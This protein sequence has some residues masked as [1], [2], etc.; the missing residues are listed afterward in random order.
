[1][2]VDYRKVSK[3]DAYPMPNV[4][5]ILDK[6][7]PA[8]FISTLDLAQGYWR[9]PMAADSQ[10]VTAFTT[11]YGLLEFTVMPFGLHNA[12]TTFQ[13][14]MNEVLSDC[15][16]FSKS[17]IDDVVVL[18]HYL[19]YVM[20]EG[21]IEPDP[22]KVE[23]VKQPVTNS[24]VRAFH[25][26]ASYYRK[27]VP[28]FATRAAPLTELLKKRQH[29]EIVWTEKCGKAFRDLKSA[30]TTKPV[31]TAPNFSQ[32]F[33]IQTDAAEG[34]GAVLSQMGEDGQELPIAYASRKLQ[35]REKNYATIK[36]EC[37]GIKALLSLHLC[38]NVYHRD[39]HS[40][41]LTSDT[42]AIAE[43]LDRPSALAL[44]L[45]E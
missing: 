5:E 2:C 44:L 4:Q 9:V 34:I 6:V 42:L 8:K 28:N 13:R 35:S 29:E 15:S 1:M 21:R 3:F 40:S 38:T 39:S 17:Y 10:E 30:L 16:A 24:E 11:P 27:F 14:T 26:L 7:G 22:K 32:P 33:V 31:L 37:L 19:G 45:P 36:K 23:A 20:G 25:G 41:T 12:P 18:V 43:T